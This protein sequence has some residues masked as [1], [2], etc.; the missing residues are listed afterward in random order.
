MRPRSHFLV[1]AVYFELVYS[2]KKV[3]QDK[4]YGH[5]VTF[6]AGG[7][8]Q[9]TMGWLDVEG[10]EVLFNTAEGRVKLRNLRSDPRVIASVQERIALQSYLVLHRTATVTEAGAD[11]H[12]DKVAKRFLGV[13]KYPYRQ[14]GEKRLVVRIKTDRIG[15]FAPKMQRWK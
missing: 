11:A 3:L 8:P 2:A 5:V 9:L 12:V 7:R 4:A 6:N 10:D 13:G 15:G 1:P 14:L